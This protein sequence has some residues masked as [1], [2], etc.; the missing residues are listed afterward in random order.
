[1]QW[2]RDACHLIPHVNDT[3]NEFQRFSKGKKVSIAEWRSAR[4]KLYDQYE[5]RIVEGATV[6]I[7]NS[8]C[9]YMT[10]T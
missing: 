2:P 9:R 4:D 8:A 10:L 3:W 1:M 6:A 5:R 7:S